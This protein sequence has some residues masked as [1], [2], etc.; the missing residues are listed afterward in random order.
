[1]LLCR[2]V[3]G[4]NAVECYV[5]ECVNVKEGFAIES[6]TVVT[7]FTQSRIRHLLYKLSDTI[8]GTRL[9]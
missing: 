8:L 3:D 5:I 7:A 9:S 6:G 2:C 4:T 1:M